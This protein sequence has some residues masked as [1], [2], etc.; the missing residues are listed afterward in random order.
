MHFV[1]SVHITLNSYFVYRWLDRWIDHM[2]KMM[3]MEGNTITNVTANSNH[4]E[5][6]NP[7]YSE[8]LNRCH[9]LRS[10]ADPSMMTQRFTLH[11]T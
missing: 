4:S 10:I 11:V 6:L 8:C 9:G 5:P 7:H 3:M 1:V 2:Q